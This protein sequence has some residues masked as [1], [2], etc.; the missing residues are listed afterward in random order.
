VRRREAGEQTR[1]R[2]L[3]AAKKLF[4][5]KGYFNTSVKDIAKE[6]GVSP[7]TVYHYFGSK[8]DLA[9]EIC[10]EIIGVIRQSIENAI[11]EG[12][13]AEDRIKRI[14]VA[15]SK[16]AWDDLY[17][18]HTGHLLKL[19]LCPE[20]PYAVLKRFLRE[21]KKRGAIKDL[22]EDLCAVCLTG[23]PIGL[24]RLKRSGTIKGELKPYVE[25]LA[26]CVWRSLRS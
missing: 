19:P 9:G 20:E 6:S 26:E 16:L 18:I 3:T 24:A 13:T 10:R 21:E 4:A 15:F 1:R 23:A 22:N 7:A 8:E 14:M 5:E 12:S 11:R 17:V 2:I 25:E